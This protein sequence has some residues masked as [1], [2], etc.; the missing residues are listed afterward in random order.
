MSLT[1][2]G[3]KLRPAEARR[4]GGRVFGEG[5]SEPPSPRAGGP[6]RPTE[7]LK[8]GA[9]KVTTEMLYNVQA[10]VCFIPETTEQLKL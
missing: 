7:N 3:T 8:F 9:T 1:G 5:G 6:G 2:K 10:I 4:A